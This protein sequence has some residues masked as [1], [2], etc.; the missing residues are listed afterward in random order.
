M[1]MQNWGT[2]KVHFGRCASGKCSGQFID[3]C[4]K[5]VSIDQYHK[6]MLGAQVLTH[7][8]SPLPSY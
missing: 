3:S 6:T 1:F 4:Q 2:N 8:S 7:Q 5:R